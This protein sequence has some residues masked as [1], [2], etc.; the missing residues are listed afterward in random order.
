MSTV[1]FRE[2][3]KTDLDAIVALMTDDPLGATRESGKDSADSYTRAFAEIAPDGEDVHTVV[4]SAP[5]W[6][7][8]HARPQQFTVAHRRALRV[9]VDAQSI[10]PH[11]KPDEKTVRGS[12]SGAWFGT[13]ECWMKIQ[14]PAKSDVTVVL[15]TTRKLR[16]LVADIAR[17][18]EVEV[19]AYAAWSDTR[20]R[21]ILR[22]VETV[23]AS[24]DG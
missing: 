24:A 5:S 16:R 7:M 13:D 23:G 11:P 3:N 6:T 12:F 15:V 19:I 17:P 20:E 4:C 18:R 8:R 10:A 9:A 1:I 22:H 21:L 2:A 14:E